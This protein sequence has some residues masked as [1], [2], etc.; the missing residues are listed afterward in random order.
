MLRSNLNYT[1]IGAIFETG[2]HR[3]LDH[4]QVSLVDIAAAITEAYCRW[5]D[6]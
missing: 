6:E 3:F 2:L 5:L 1:T 4:T